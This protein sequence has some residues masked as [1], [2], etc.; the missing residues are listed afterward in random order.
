MEAELKK[1]KIGLLTSGSVFLS[2]VCFNLVHRFT[3]EIPTAATDGKS[4]LFNPDFF[5]KQDKD[6]KIGLLA[7]E[8]WHVALMH[9]TRRGDKDPTIYNIAGD[10][11]INLLLVDAGFKI[12][13]GGCYDRKYKGYTTEQVYEELI[14]NPEDIPQDINI[15]LM[16][17]GL[18]GGELS[19]EQRQ[20][21]ESEI[22]TILVKAETQARMA[23][24]AGEIPGEVLRIIDDLI[25]P[26]L[27]WKEL[28]QRYVSAK[29]KEDYS[30]T[31]PNRRHFPRFY[32]PSLYSDAIGHIT[33]AIDT[34]GSITDADITAML[35]EIKNLYEEYKPSKLTIM[36]CDWSIHNVYEVERDN[37]EDILDLKF[38]G[39]GGTS[40]EPVIDYCKNHETQVLVYFTD[41]YADPIEEELDFD[42]IWL[43]YSG[44][45]PA[46]I[47]ETV[48]YQK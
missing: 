4:V 30:W 47:G 19:P 15:D 11:V 22:K 21:L 16:E 7:H 35:T 8:T 44:H 39:G 5:K 41:L 13:E 43:C 32:L 1:A 36:D 18:N 26:K 48:Y 2:T 14:Q 29:I 42:V 10:F 45:E 31:R 37:L 24:Q 27:N 33:I 20:S 38:T 9:L 34:S 6:Q 17:G 25:N 23:N 46:I 28:L 3:E 12:P 40:F